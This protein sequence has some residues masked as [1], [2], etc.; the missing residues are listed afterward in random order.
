MVVPA[1]FLIVLPAGTLIFPPGPSMK[2]LMD[3]LN[4]NEYVNYPALAGGASCFI[5]LPTGSEST[6][7]NSAFRACYPDKI[8]ILQGE[9]LDIDC[10][11]DVVVV[12]STAVRTDPFSI[13]KSEILLDIPTTGTDFR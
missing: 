13:V 5:L 7:S 11:V 2:A 6:G 4:R 3:G 12:V 9:L 1:A 10:R 8:L